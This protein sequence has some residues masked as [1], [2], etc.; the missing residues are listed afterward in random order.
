MTLTTQGTASTTSLDYSNQRFVWLSGT[1]PHASIPGRPD[2]GQ[3]LSDNGWTN[4][5][6]DVWI[7]LFLSNWRLYAN[8]IDR[9]S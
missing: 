9:S 8:Y 2:L 5:S 6:L 1:P 7:Q 3:V 4:D